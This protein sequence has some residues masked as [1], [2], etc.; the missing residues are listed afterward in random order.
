MILSKAKLALV[1]VALFAAGCA[2][3]DVAEVRNL[4]EK[5]TPFQNELHKE[6]VRLAQL[7]ANEYDWFDTAFFNKRARRAAAGEDFGPQAIEERSLPKD[8]I[9]EMTEARNRLVAALAA[10]KNEKPIPAARAQAGFD[11]WMQEQEENFQPDDIAACK[12]SFDAAMKD[13]EAKPMAAKPAP[14]PPPPPPAPPKPAPVVVPPPGPFLMTF[15]FDRSDINHQR[16]NIIREAAR[17]AKEEHVKRI[18]IIGHADRR[19]SDAYNA[20]LSQARVNAVAAFL[21]QQGIDPSIITKQAVGESEP[22]VPTP[23]NQR[24]RSNRRV[25]IRMEK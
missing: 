22:A 23:D 5:G 18:I 10:G 16:A 6:Y 7:E 2:N 14:P 24:L 8:K 15:G 4:P 25:E 20:R 17:Q 21:V 9:G 19:G 3:L 12:R 13:L 11:C 1:G